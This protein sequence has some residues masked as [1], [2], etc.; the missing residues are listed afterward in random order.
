MKTLLISD[1]HSNIVALEAIWAKEKDCDQAICAGDLV[2][3]GFWP[4]EVIAW[5][6]AHN[7]PCVM[8][9]HDDWVVQNFYKLNE[10]SDTAE[11]EPGWEVHN[12]K[13]LNNDGVAFLESLPQTLE[14]ELDRVTCGMCHLVNGYDELVSLHAFKAFT[15]EYFPSN[16]SR[17]IL[18]HTHRQAVRYLSDHL[19][20]LNPGSV[21]YRRWDDPDPTAHY[22]TIVDGEIRFHRLEYDRE[23]LKQ[24][25]AQVKLDENAMK[26][27]RRIFG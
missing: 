22:M 10:V 21:S 19:C 9:N 20:W 2:D 27:G 13:L 25:F 24:A 8:G 15:A 7:V 17:L 11:S 4:N 14:I 18:G 6:Q 26:I 23:P 12:A 16:P 3:V 1:I 5:I